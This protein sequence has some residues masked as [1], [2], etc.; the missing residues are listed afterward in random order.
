M[1]TNYKHTLVPLGDLKPGTPVWIPDPA[2][3]GGRSGPPILTTVHAVQAAYPNME[4]RQLQLNNFSTVP[5]TATYL[6]LAGVPSTHQH[7]RGRP[8]YFEGLPPATP[9][10]ALTGSKATTVIAQKWTTLLVRQEHPYYTIQSSGC[11]PEIFV[12]RGD[13]TILPAWEFLPQKASK[14]T[15]S[16]APAYWDGWQAEF[17]PQAGHCHEFLTDRI[18]TGLRNVLEAARQV[19]KSSMLTLRSVVPVTQE[20][21]AAAAPE[22]VAFGCLPSLN[23]YGAI[24][25]HPGDPRAFPYRM[26]GGH[27]HLGQKS[28][29]LN[30][31]RSA[32]IGP[33]PLHADAVELV[34]TLDATAGVATV[35]MFAGLDDTFRRKFY[36]LAGE[37]RLPEHGVEYRVLSNAWLCHP[38]VCHLTLD[39]VR[40]MQGWTG[41]RK[42]LGLDDETEVQ[43]IINQ[44]DVGAARAWVHSH[45]AVY[46]NFFTSRYGNSHFAPEHALRCIYEGVESLIG[47]VTA[48]T[49]TRA[50]CLLR[51]HRSW[52]IQSG[53]SDAQF[54]FLVRDLAAPAAAV[55]GATAI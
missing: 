6:T 20:A 5:G 26:A 23:A 21:L 45:E 39:L 49:M 15:T 33:S 11:D 41:G 47:E 43:R 9:I 51:S 14:N 32:Y 52:T 28:S 4:L 38:A 16:P 37:Y 46:R 48:E 34:K 12:T 55:K 22:H 1:S 17:S 7:Y 44:C 13:G 24:A 42:A 36:G 18:Q 8:G 27:I 29:T 53:N 25:Q 3:L 2:E 19:D 40:G 50:W 10:R 35:G 31:T 30:A 54:K